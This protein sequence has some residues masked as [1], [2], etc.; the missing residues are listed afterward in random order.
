[1]LRRTQ[2]CDTAVHLGKSLLSIGMCQIG[3]QP[4]D[5]CPRNPD[6]LFPA[7]LLRLPM[8]ARPTTTIF[9]WLHGSNL[10]QALLDACLFR[11]CNSNIVFRHHA[12]QSRG[13]YAQRRPRILVPCLEL[14]DVN[15]SHLLVVYAGKQWKDDCGCSR[16]ECGVANRL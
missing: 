14:L 6:P 3:D 1:M 11:V 15:P 4:T 13:T 16:H 5:G 7:C 10:D 8:N 9:S 12:L 2:N